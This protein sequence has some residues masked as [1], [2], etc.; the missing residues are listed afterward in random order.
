MRE[1][2]VGGEQ[3]LEATGKLQDFTGTLGQRGRGME[4]ATEDLTTT[5]NYTKTTSSEVLERVSLIGADVSS[6]NSAMQSVGALSH[7]LDEMTARVDAAVKVF[8]T[9]KEVEERI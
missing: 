3:I 8:T 2:S 6:I 4:A 1:L 7:T 5:M 9:E